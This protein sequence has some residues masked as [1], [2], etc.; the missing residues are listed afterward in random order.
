MLGKSSGFCWT[1]ATSCT[2]SGERASGISGLD[3]E[4]C[5]GAPPPPPVAP[6]AGAGADGVDDAAA[7]VGWPRGML[8]GSIK[9]SAA[10]AMFPNAARSAA[11][12]SA[13]GKPI[14][15]KFATCSGVP[16]LGPPVDGVAAGGVG[17]AA[18]VAEA[19]D[20][21]SGVAAAGL[22]GTKK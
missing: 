22:H 17:F 18:G 14:A 10:L 4:S 2:N 6:E 12:H 19:S 11:W 9:Y 13:S 5:G 7:G 20:V 1:V 15:T 21:A 8:L 16:T 3:D